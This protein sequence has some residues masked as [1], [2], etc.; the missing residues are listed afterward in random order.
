MPNHLCGTNILRADPSTLWSAR[1][2]AL[3]LM[4]FDSFRSSG[5]IDKEHRDLSVIS[6][7]VNKGPKL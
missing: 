2:R 4:P 5:E 6:L 1:F 7:N 3:L